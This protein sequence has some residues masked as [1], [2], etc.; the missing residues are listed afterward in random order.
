MSTWALSELEALFLRSRDIFKFNSFVLSEKK[1]KNNIENS[2]NSLL[3]I[4]WENRGM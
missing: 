2:K 3:L 1:L 4:Y